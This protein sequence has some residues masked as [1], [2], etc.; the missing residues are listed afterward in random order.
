MDMLP[1]GLAYLKF[2]PSR[3]RSRSRSSG[4]LD[5]IFQA[6]EPLQVTGR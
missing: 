6:H 3:V 2:E 1:F 5:R 4:A